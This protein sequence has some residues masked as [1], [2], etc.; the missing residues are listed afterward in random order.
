MKRIRFTIS[1]RGVPETCA[2]THVLTVRCRFPRR[3]IHYAAT[4]TNANGRFRF[5]SPLP[6]TFAPV[7]WRLA[8]V[9]P[10]RGRSKGFTHFSNVGFVLFSIPTSRSLRARA[11]SV[12]TDIIRVPI[13]KKPWESYVD[14]RFVKEPR[15]G[16][17][18]VFDN[19]NDNR[20]VVVVTAVLKNTNLPFESSC[21]SFRRPDRVYCFFRRSSSGPRDDDG[22]KLS[23]AFRS[24]RER[25][26]E[27]S[28]ET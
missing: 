14:I 27:S 21:Y 16:R 23:A 8:M 24:T 25:P 2:T 10:A 5:F 20:R 15:S 11:P 1:T 3:F 19:R 26:T 18:S 17:V 12:R 7:P 13:P 6:S 22:A 28:R 9:V 4:F